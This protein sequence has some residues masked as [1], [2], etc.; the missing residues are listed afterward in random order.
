[1]KNKLLPIVI[2]MAMIS[3]I[4][5]A[6]KKDKSPTP[7]TPTVPATA[8]CTASINGTATSFP[9]NYYQ[10]IS[11]GL[12]IQAGAVTATVPPYI[13]LYT[14]FSQTT[15]TYTIG[16]TGVGA[17]YQDASGTGHFAAS[18]TI[19]YSSISGNKVSGSFS[20]V[21]TDGINVTSGTFSNVPL[22]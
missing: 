21:T 6:C 3:M 17:T 14:S 11:G 22:L 12:Y 1:M 2:C 10:L 7:T 9:A 4:S 15:G 13:Q 5:P 8:T 16:T 20:F 19:T 18:G